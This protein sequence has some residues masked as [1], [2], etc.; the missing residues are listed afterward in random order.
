LLPDWQLAFRRGLDILTTLRRGVYW[1]VP[2][3]THLSLNAEWL[4]R[5]GTTREHQLGREPG[6]ASGARLID[7]RFAVYRT[8]GK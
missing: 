7:E 8:G 2:L 3:R 1:A 4:A 6:K 5:Y